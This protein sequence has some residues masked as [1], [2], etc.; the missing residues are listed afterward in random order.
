MSDDARADLAVVRAERKAGA[1]RAN[2]AQAIWGWHPSSVVPFG[3]WQRRRCRFGCR[4]GTPARNGLVRGANASHKDVGG[5]M[6]VTTDPGDRRGLFRSVQKG[7]WLARFAALAT[8]RSGT[9]GGICTSPPCSPGPPPGPSAPL[10]SAYDAESDVSAPRIVAEV[11][12]RL[13]S[14]TAAAG[15]RPRPALSRFLFFERPRP[16]ALG[17]R[18]GPAVRPTPP[19]HGDHQRRVREIQSSPR[20]CP[21]NTASGVAS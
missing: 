14:P 6:R 21:H 11:R 9:W 15:V 18:H 4:A 1:E 13:K 19:T 10:R 8:A 12:L 3:A 20:A 2:F 7:I 17:A 5:A 16:P